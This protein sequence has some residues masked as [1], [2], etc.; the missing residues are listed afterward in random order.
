MPPTP[1]IGFVLDCA[2]PDT[3]TGFWSTALGWNHLG[4][5][6]HYSVIAAPGPGGQ[7]LL[8]QRVPEPKAGKNRMHLDLHVADVEAEADRLESLGAT[9]LADAQEGYGSTWIVMA[10]PEGNEF[11]VCDMAG[12]C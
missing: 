7:K 11:C 2:D 1:S 6:G 10:D 9:R 8:L 5:D 3:L 12:D 4:S